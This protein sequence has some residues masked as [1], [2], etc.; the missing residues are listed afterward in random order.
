MVRLIL[1]A[2]FSAYIF[3][4]L[5]L[6]DGHACNRQVYAQKRLSLFFDGYSM[7][8]RAFQTEYE[9]L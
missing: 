7:P 5:I 3:N 9:Q 8:K 4:N 2:S 6:Q 1:H